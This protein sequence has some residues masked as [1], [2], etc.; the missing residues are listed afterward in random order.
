MHI[1]AGA[2][3]WLPE[4]LYAKLGRYRHTVFIERLGW[5]LDTPVG[6]ERDQ[7]DRADT[8]YV[9]AQNNDGRITGCARLLPTTRPYLL[10]EVFPQLLNGLPPPNSPDVWELS[11]FAA[12][13]L[14]GVGAA[15]AGAQ[16]ASSVAA[17]LL[18]ESV[19]CAAARGAKRL[20]SVSPVGAERLIQ[21]AGFQAHR[22][23]PPMI[24]NGHP[25]FA[26]CI[27]IDESLRMDSLDV[28]SANGLCLV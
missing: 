16:F 6:F 22:V 1:V 7:F 26:C 19:A 18:R 27:D 5:R 23:G 20:I 8:V 10:G 4:G 15:S 25:I 11:R 2:R 28:R 14:N 12:M 9:V 17:T 3:E 24:E 21:R 13:D